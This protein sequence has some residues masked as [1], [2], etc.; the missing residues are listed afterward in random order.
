MTAPLSNMC[1]LS[2]NHCGGLNRRGRWSPGRVFD[3]ATARSASE[4]HTAHR[5]V[6]A[7]LALHP[8]VWRQE[9]ADA[10]GKAASEQCSEALLD[11]RKNERHEDGVSS[12]LYEAITPVPSEDDPLQEFLNAC[13]ELHPLAW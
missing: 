13:C 5:A 10:E 6:S 2:N 12:P 9:Q 7:L 4:D 8:R 3:P 11:P 1:F